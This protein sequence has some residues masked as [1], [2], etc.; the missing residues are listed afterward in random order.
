[1]RHSMSDDLKKYIR[2]VRDFPKDGIVFRDITTLLKE[3]IA[4][5]KTATALFDFAKN[6]NVS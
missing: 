4:L 3:P 2:N 1:M 6:K 5:K